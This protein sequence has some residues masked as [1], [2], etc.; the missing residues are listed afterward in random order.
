MK[1]TLIAALLAGGL[2]PGAFAAIA[3]PLGGNG[4][5]FLVVQNTA[6]QVSYSFDTGIRMDTFF[7]NGEVPGSSLSFNIAS[8]P[9]WQ[10]FVAAASSIESSAWAIMAFDGTGN[11]QPGNQRLLTTARQQATPAAT[12]ALVGQ[13]T[14]AQFSLGVTQVAPQ[15]WFA[16]V[17]VSGTHANPAGTPLFPLN[18]EI[19]GS[20]VNFATATVP[21]GYF[22]Q[23]GGLTPT[24]NGNAPF[25][26]TN[27]ISPTSSSTFYYLTRSSTGNLASN[28]VIV[29]PFQTEGGLATWSF[30]G[31]QLTYTA[32]VPEP[33]TYALL[34][35]G[36]L[37]IGLKLRQH[38]R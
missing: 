1:K 16:E 31:Q 10:A 4:E 30:N 7:A 3:G 37:G 8:D 33:T 22:G 21:F 24:F 34:A 14:N 12:A 2:V 9:N 18:E 11:N 5:I 26:S 23:P 36:L 32:P 25:Q 29:D 6:N 15:Q 20:S 38:R 13:M 28:R 35:L 19:N 27:F 17:N